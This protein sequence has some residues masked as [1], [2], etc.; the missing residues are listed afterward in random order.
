[1]FYKRICTNYEAHNRVIEKFN[2]LCQ[3]HNHRLAHYLRHLETILGN[4]T[5]YLHR[6]LIIKHP[7]EEGEVAE[8]PEGSP[9][10]KG[11]VSS[12]LW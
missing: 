12:S 5:K 7:P 4:R 9:R 11:T 6:L 1:M 3:I 10:L 2:Q 8:D